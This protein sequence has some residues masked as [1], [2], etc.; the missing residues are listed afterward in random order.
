MEPL[1]LEESNDASDA[2]A[3]LMRQAAASATA[4]LLEEKRQLEPPT[5]GKTDQSL[6]SALISECLRLE[7]QPSKVQRYIEL[8]GEDSTTPNDL[9]LPEAAKKDATKEPKKPRKSSKAKET[10]SCARIQAYVPSK[11]QN[12]P[13]AAA[14]EV[15]PAEAQNKSRKRP[16]NSPGEGEQAPG[17]KRSRKSSKR[18]SAS[19]LNSSKEEVDV[20]HVPKTIPAKEKQPTL[21]PRR[22]GRTPKKNV[23]SV[24]PSPNTSAQ[25]IDVLL[26]DP[27][28]TE[29]AG[30][31]TTD[32]SSKLEKVPT[33]TRKV[34]QKNPLT[35]PPPEKTR[36]PR[37]ASPTKLS[38]PGLPPRG[39]KAISFNQMSGTKKPPDSSQTTVPE[40][41]NKEPPN[42]EVVL[43]EVAVPSN[44]GKDV[45]EE[46]VALNLT[47][48]KPTV[49]VAESA[50]S[51]VLEQPAEVVTNADDVQ[52]NQPEETPSSSVVTV[53]ESIPTSASNVENRQE[54]S[55]S[56]EPNMSALDYLGL[57]PSL[58]TKVSATIRP[59]RVEPNATSNGVPR[60][61]ENV[62]QQL[63]PQ[64]LRNLEKN[65][66]NQCQKKLSFSQEICLFSSK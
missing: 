60:H 16:V 65:F 1:Q 8:F 51:T 35:S 29:K 3:A 17:T 31:S 47:V 34:S 7:D 14:V 39:R 43:V 56:T 40:M 20:L 59:E 49:N 23:D 36:T 10:S 64:E 62:N 48:E 54:R 9:V 32:E 11:R 2:A 38:N 6:E 25:E 53:A 12:K 15:Y 50:S 41:V 57:L 18:K 46:P 61:P 66:V 4:A 24:R 26:V 5:P 37:K 21:A 27:V 63:N 58:G 13:A 30:T 44:E 22:S 33:K 19:S 28:L 42:P 45:V 55:S 52:P